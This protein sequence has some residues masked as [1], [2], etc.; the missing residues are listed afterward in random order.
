MKGADALPPHRS[1]DCPIK[2]LLGAKI[3]F[4]P[5]FPLS[6]PELEALWDY[7]NENFKKGFA[8]AGILFVEKKD[9]SLR[10][11]VDYR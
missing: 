4:G 7:L 6:E 9:H 10:P 1:N 11:C 5:I 8:G 2:L 3:L